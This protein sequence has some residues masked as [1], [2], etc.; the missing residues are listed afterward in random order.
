MPCFTHSR[1]CVKL[2]SVRKPKEST[3]TRVKNLSL[4]LHEIYFGCR[5]QHSNLA[6]RKRY[7]GRLLQR[8]RSVTLKPRAYSRVTITFPAGLSFT[9]WRSESVTSS[10]WKFAR[11]DSAT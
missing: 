4:R 8:R 6:T 11:F 9:S 5:V 1:R 2:F 10:D 7:C 3:C